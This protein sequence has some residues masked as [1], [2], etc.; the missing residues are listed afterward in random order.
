MKTS[1]LKLLAAT[2][3]IFFSACSDDKDAPSSS[4]FKPQVRIKS[5]TR[6]SSLPYSTFGYDSEGRYASFSFDSD[7]VV[8][9][10]YSPF[11]IGGYFNIS[12]PV[13]NKKGHITSLTIDNSGENGTLEASYDRNGYLTRLEITVDGQ[14]NV[15]TIT[16]K[17]GLLMSVKSTG[18]G[19]MG[20]SN[21]QDYI[22]EYSRTKPVYNRKKQW[23]TVLAQSIGENDLC[24]PL[25]FCGFLGYAPK[26]F[27]QKVTLIEKDDN[28]KEIDRM[29]L[30]FDFIL[31]SYGTIATEAAD[32]TILNYSYF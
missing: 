27:P 23:S 16:W 25:A 9:F 2:L 28:G 4:D 20:L 1:P 22:F 14:T 11:A 3:L 29:P 19:Y 18:T 17:D 24:L 6:G 32:G 21:A 7:P 31:N 26:Q 13:I 30:D 12:N 8:T 10:S 15:R 5:I